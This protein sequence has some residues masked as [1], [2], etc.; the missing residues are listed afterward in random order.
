MPAPSQEFVPISEIRDGV[1]V[2]TDGGYRAVLAVTPLNLSLKSQAEQEGTIAGFQE[3]INILD[4]SVQ[5]V[6]QSRKLD[7][8]EYLNL[9]D[10]RLNIIEEELLQIQTE[11]YIEYIR[12]LSQDRAIMKKYFFV[13]VPYNGEN[14]QVSAKGFFSAF[15]GKGKSEN[16]L[17]FEENRLQLAQRVGV[18]QS[19]LSG[20]G[21]KS[22]QL[23]TKELVE[24]YYKLYNPG[25]A[26][27]SFIN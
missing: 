22:D 25:D 15:S 10:S 19:G 8:T 26:Q 17:S 11:N 1:V 13:I 9:L 5:I 16:N 4:F 21:L 24:L 3:F 18:I 14:S 2:L 23:E 27:S 12:T 7:L 6:I 20:A